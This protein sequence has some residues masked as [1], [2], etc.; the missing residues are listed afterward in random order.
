M[1]EF[2]HPVANACM[3]GT[4]LAAV[5]P[6]SVD[7][8]SHPAETV[9]NP[10]AL[11]LYGRAGQ[12]LTLCVATAL[13]AGAAG[14]LVGLVGT[15]GELPQGQAWRIAFVHL[16]AAWLSLTLFAAT[17]ALAL[18]EALARPPWPPVVGMA[19]AP[20]GA[21]MS[22]GRRRQILDYAAVHGVWVIEDDYDSEFQFKH[23]PIASLQGFAQGERVIFV[24]SFSKTMQPA[25]GLG[26]L[27][28]PTP[29]IQRAAPIV[30]AI[31][32]DVPLL[33]QAALADFISE[34][35]FSRH[36]RKMRKLYQQKQQLAQQLAAQYLPD[37]RLSAMH[38]GLH[39]VLLCPDALQ[40]KFDGPRLLQR[41]AAQGYAPAP[42]SKYQFNGEKTMGLV[43][44]I[45]NISHAEL[46][47]GLQLIA[48]HCC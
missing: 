47:L 15:P 36:L 7:R 13:A 11:L 25:L 35:H 38:A 40:S 23:R 10:A 4:L 19:L 12:W 45:A 27:V 16:P 29:L 28:A 2:R 46:E 32:G 34:G 8:P 6:M 44:G 39:L 43:I 9:G 37:W 5:H 26:Y 21:L 48:E 1:G 41:L 17:T 33:T 18:V 22:H 42:L 24:G 30:Q 3:P 20:S 14:A 31:H